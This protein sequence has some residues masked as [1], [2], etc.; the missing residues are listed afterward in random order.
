[1]TTIFY[2]CSFSNM[3]LTVL[4]GCSNNLQRYIHQLFHISLGTL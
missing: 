3:G 2:L 1:M 4:Y